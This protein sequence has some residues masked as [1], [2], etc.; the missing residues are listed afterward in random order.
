MLLSGL[1]ELRQRPDKIGGDIRERQ[2]RA[3][4]VI[5]ERRQTL[6]RCLDNVGTTCGQP[7]LMPV[8]A[9]ILINQ[10]AVV[11]APTSPSGKR[12]TAVG[13][14]DAASPGHGR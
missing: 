4:A 3:G 14:S 1:N 5:L 8:P 9:S 2:D 11:L 6:G 13:R 12:V 10:G 7:F